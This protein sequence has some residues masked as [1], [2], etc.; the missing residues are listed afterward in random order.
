VPFGSIEFATRF[1]SKDKV[2]VA[3][4]TAVG[5]VRLMIVTAVEVAPSQQA[6]ELVFRPALLHGPDPGLAV[7]NNCATS[8]V[9]DA[10][11]V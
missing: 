2:V 5:V 9:V 11:T 8:L 4:L 10:V 3:P 6:D 7:L 1:A